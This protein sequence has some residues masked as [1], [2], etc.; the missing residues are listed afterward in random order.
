LTA[1]GMGG[2]LFLPLLAPENQMAYDTTQFY[3]AALG[4]LAGCAT[5]TLS[6][7][8]LPPLSPAFRTHRLL[9]LTLR[10]LHR[11][12]TGPLWRTDDWEGLVYSRLA[13]LPD[14]ALLLQRAQLVTALFTGTEI[15]RL[16]RIAPRLGLGAELAAALAALAQDSSTTATAQ[17]ALIDRRLAPLAKQEAL[18]PLALRA[19]SSILALSDALTQHASYFDA[20]APA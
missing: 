2:F 9:A 18:A 12:A 7:L 3:N 8:L 15:I 1:M 14:G 13:V 6:F 5:A 17:L 10:D 11:L 19:R 16:R 20:R 4:I